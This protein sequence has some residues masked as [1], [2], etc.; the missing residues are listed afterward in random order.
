MFGIGMPELI[1]ILVLAL[2]ILGPKKLPD[3]ARSLGKGLAEFRKATNELKESM[4]VDE[5]L[6]EVKKSVA[7][8]VSEVRNI[9]NLASKGLKDWEKAAIAQEKKEIEERLAEDDGPSEKPISGDMKSEMTASEESPYPGA[10]IHEDESAPS[11]DISK[12]A[13]SSA[14]SVL[15]DENEEPGE[16]PCLSATD[17]EKNIS[18]PAKAPPSP[19]EDVLS[20]DNPDTAPSQPSKDSPK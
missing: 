2:I 4:N 12:E 5:D 3:L 19:S 1:V 13:D 14:S 8:A 16:K 10:A 11:S 9:E 17:A 7:D 18:D 15:A 20:S 6:S